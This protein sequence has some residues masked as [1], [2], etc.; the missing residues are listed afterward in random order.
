[1]SETEQSRLQSII[2][3]MGSESRQSIFFALR[4]ASMFGASTMT[5]EHLLLAICRSDSA[6]STWLGHDE[7]ELVGLLKN[8]SAMHI[9]GPERMQRISDALKFVSSGAAPIPTSSDMPLDEALKAALLRSSEEANALRS[10][11]VLDVHLLLGILGSKS[12]AAEALE[13]AGVTAEELRRAT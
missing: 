12:V 2:G 5:L 10:D 11:E 9:L 6:I 4:L 3:R 13:R 8:T 1:V 7:A